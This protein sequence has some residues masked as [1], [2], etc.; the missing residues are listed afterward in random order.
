MTNTNPV[1]E[2]I[3]NR[4][5][6][7]R[8]SPEPLSREMLELLVRAGMYAPS[9]KNKRSWQFIVCD[10][11]NVIDKIRDVHPYGAMLENCP[12][13]IFI[14][15]DRNAESSKNY[16]LEDCAAATQNILLAAKSLGL[17]T[18][19]LGVRPSETEMIHKYQEMFNLPENI[20]PFNFIAVGTPAMETQMPDRFEEEKLHWNMW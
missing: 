17:G 6:I 10:E 4:R 1:L 9:G 18:C 7:R 14:C 8:Y 15:G 12:A 13:C 20:I 3:F 19:W 11:R 2:T 5:S 16:F